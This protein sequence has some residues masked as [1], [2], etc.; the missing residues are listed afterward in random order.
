M[1]KTFGQVHIEDGVFHIFAFLLGTGVERRWSHS[2]QFLHKHEKVMFT[3]VTFVFPL[4]DQL[5]VE[6]EVARNGPALYDGALLHEIRLDTV[7]VGLVPH[8]LHVQILRLEETQ[9]ALGEW[10]P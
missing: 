8:N 7:L 4:V 1:L 9:Q 2:L 5:E 6:L 10:F 3:D